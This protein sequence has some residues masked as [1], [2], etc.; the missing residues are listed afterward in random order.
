MNFKEE[1]LKE[2]ANKFEAC[3]ELLKKEVPNMPSSV[4]IEI[5]HNILKI[6]EVKR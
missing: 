2:R 5:V 3:I 4:A 1:A 6:W